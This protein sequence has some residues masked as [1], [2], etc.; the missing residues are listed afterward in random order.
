[1]S[2]SPLASLSPD[3]DA[4]ELA[5]VLAR[6]ILSGH[7]NPGDGFPRELD[8]CRHF[9]V[10]RNLVRNA[11]ASLTSAGLIERSA[12]RGSWVR[13]IGDWHLLDPQMSVWMTGL[14][15]T[16]PQLMREIFAFRLSAEPH[17]AE[18]A[19][20][21]AD[22]EDL[23]RLERAWN[24]MRDSAGD[25]KRR[26]E[27]AECDVAFHAAVYRASHNL[28]WRQMGHLLRPSI[29]ALIQH[30]QRR[31]GDLDD[32]LER[33]R[34]VMEAIRLRQP[35]AARLATAQVLERTA[36]DLSKASSTVASSSSIPEL[37]GP[38]L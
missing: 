38:G 28:V 17:V 29:I 12:G 26:N 27:H 30:S 23:A 2:L 32:S 9:A 11:L 4:R 34:R 14:E 24:G 22:A 16:H 35:Q 31:A 1:M 37:Q 21:A 5:T 13:E 20:Q 25:P 15:T 19:A 7:W 18:L 10:S 8:L 6:A 33:H 3:A 36:D